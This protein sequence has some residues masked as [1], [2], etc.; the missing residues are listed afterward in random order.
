MIPGPLVIMSPR[1]KQRQIKNLQLV[2]EAT[3][4]GVSQAGAEVYW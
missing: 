1:R 3:Q 2:Q 4:N